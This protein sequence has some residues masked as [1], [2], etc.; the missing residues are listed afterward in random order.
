MPAEKHHLEVKKIQQEMLNKKNDSKKLSLSDNNSSNSLR[1]NHYRKS[2]STV[3]INHLTHV[4][5]VDAEKRRVT[6]EPRVTMDQLVRTTLPYGFLPAVVPEFKGITVGGAIMGAAIESSSHRY[7]QF[8]DACLGM[9]ILLGSGEIVHASAK[10]NADLFYGMSSSF[11]TL[12]ILTSAEIALVPASEWVELTYKAFEK[13][14]QAIDYLAKMQRRGDAPDFLEGIVYQFDL[15]VVISGKMRKEVPEEGKQFSLSPSSLWFYCHV[16]QAVKKSKQEVVEYVPTYDYL[17][18]HDRGAFWMG[19][20]ALHLSLSASLATNHFFPKAEKLQEW[21]LK[22]KPHLSKPKYPGKLFCSLFG[23]Y[24]DSQ[25]LY[26]IL[27]SG[28]ES[29]FAQHCVVQDFYVP[30]EKTAY[31]V[32]Q[33]MEQIGILPIWLCPIKPTHEPQI[34]A[35]HYQKGSLLF[36]VGVYGFPKNDLTGQQATVKLESFARDIDAKKMLYA[37]TFYS[38]AQFW[39]IYSREEYQQLRK[40]YGADGVFRE[41][42]EKVLCQ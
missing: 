9:E 20:C 23:K 16:R 18:R 12:G 26:H 27:H 7:G 38:L 30:E 33:V 31:F 42:T 35:P 41:V 32:G 22:D 21:F 10:E 3:S 17:F 34:L 8:N 29:W 19:G 2:S 39:S 28:T 5:D 1:A 15:T 6:V 13:P 25:S 11:G 14:Q 24:M 40:K 36:D 37:H 4:L